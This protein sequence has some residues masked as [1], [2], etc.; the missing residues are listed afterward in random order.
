MKMVKYWN[1]LPKNVVESILPDV[2]DSIGHGPE[3]PDL[4]TLQYFKQDVG[5]EGG[6]FQLI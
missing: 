4:I 3:Q 1:S 6:F 2:Q 5:L